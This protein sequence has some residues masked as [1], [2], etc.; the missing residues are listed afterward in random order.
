MENLTKRFYFKEETQINDLVVIL[1]EAEKNVT[2]VDF[3]QVQEFTL[4]TTRRDEWWKVSLTLLN[5]PLIHLN[6]FLQTSHFTGKEI[7][8]VGG[9]KFFI[10]A[11][12]THNLPPEDNKDNPDTPPERKGPDFTL[13]R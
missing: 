7:F 1:K 8:T 6:I 3:A 4:D 9:K 11:I 12:N 13:V 10:K 2:L 5:I